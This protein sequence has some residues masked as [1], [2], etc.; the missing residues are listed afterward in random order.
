MR[1]GELAEKLQRY[2]FLLAIDRENGGNSVNDIR[3]VSGT[4]NWGR[5][6]RI[7]GIFH[8]ALVL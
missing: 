6:T 2:V 7:S 5:F 1:G 8:N 3:H 4:K